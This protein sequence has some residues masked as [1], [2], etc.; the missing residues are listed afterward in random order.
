MNEILRAKRLDG[1]WVLVAVLAGFVAALISSRGPLVSIAALAVLIA[2]VVIFRDPRLGIVGMLIALPLD[3]YGRL[4]GDY[5]VTVYQVVLLLTLA[6]WL[7]QAVRGAAPPVRLTAID[8][9]IAALLGAAL[10]SL[11]FSFSRSDTLFSMGRL[12]FLV[13]FFRLV[14]TYLESDASLSRRFAATIVATS[15]AAAVLASLQHFVPGFD[16]GNTAMRLGTHL[17]PIVRGSAFFE[18]P[19][20]LGGLLSVALVV[21]LTI[22]LWEKDWRRALWWFAGSAA[23][24]VGLYATLSR[25][26]WLGAALGVLLALL[27]APKNRRGLVVVALLLGG[28]AVFALQ[29]TMLLD[30]VRSIARIG[31]DTSIS[32]RWH[33]FASAWRMIQN[34]WAMGVGLGGFAYAYPPYREFGTWLSVLKPHQLPVAMWA[35]MGIAG[36]IAEVGLTLSFMRLAL[37]GWKAGLSVESRFALVGLITLVV[38]TLFQYFLFFEYLWLLLAMAVVAIRRDI[39]RKEGAS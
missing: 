21:G 17:A 8:F 34:H 4:G 12:V 3:V 14:M 10:W 18:D 35:E 5:I 37:R 25:T 39:E 16:V 13:A 30:R 6:A 11:P 1:R 20:Y 24:A 22:G 26:A 38:Q 2:A 31:D 23:S 15:A 7:W 36:L 33:M 27:A 9:W 19:N 28:V 29:P 32:T